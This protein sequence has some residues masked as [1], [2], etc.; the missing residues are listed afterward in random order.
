MAKYTPV[1]EVRITIET[2]GNGFIVN[3]RQ[4]VIEGGAIIDDR[5]TTTV[6]ESFPKLKKYLKSLIPQIVTKEEA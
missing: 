4:G 5:T 1:P 3:V 2:R 6:F